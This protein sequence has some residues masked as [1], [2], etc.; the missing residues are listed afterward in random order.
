MFKL[1]VD[2]YFLMV[3]IACAAVGLVTMTARIPTR[4][5]EATRNPAFYEDEKYA[6]SVGARYGNEIK[7]LF[8]MRIRAKK[9]SVFNNEVTVPE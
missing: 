9:F 7:S 2:V 4:D 3:P 8:D 5:P 6:A 1:P